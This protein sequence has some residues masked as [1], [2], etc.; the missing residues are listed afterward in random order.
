MKEHEGIMKERNGI[1]L[2]GVVRLVLSY[3]RPLLGI[4][5][6]LLVSAGLIWARGVNPIVAYA[7]MLQGAFG[8]VAGLANTGVRAAPIILSGFAV[9]LGFKAGLWNIGGTGQMYLGA[10]AA[11]VVGLIPLPVPGWLHLLLAVMA[12]F[13]GGALWMLIPAYL[14]A[15]RGVN[16][17]CTTL[18]LDYVAGHFVSYLLHDTPLAAGSFYPMSPRIL[19]AARLPILVKGTSLHAGFVLALVIGGVLYFVMHHTTFGFR[20]RM[21]GENPEATRYAGVDVVRWIFLVLLICG[22]LGGLAGAGEVLGLKLRLFDYFESGVGFE[23]LALA[24]M[25]RGNS[26]GII[27]AGI[28]FA[29]LKAGASKMQIVSGIG[30]PMALVIEALAV[31]FV[32]AIGFAERGSFARLPQKKAPGKE[33]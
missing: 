20:T 11:T 3:A 16:L 30:A 9:G 6:A 4:A 10:A 13:A 31:L 12:G 33:G 27:L 25:V 14:C 5:L 8:S 19:P 17:V 21:V 26:L 18:M 23:G 2:S 1:V 15:F 7:A 29:S 24:I 28:F 32:V 22:G